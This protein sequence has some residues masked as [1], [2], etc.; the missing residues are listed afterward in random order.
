MQRSLATL[1]AD[2]DLDPALLSYG[3]LSLDLDGFAVAVRGQDVP[4]TLS[5]FLLLTAFARN[6]YRVL[7]RAALVDVLRGSAAF[8]GRD[9]ADLRLIDRHISRLRKKLH[10][11]GCDCIRTMRFAGYR[12]IPPTG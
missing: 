11:A 4:V 8:D 12:F 2:A 1:V 10:D 7:D 3:P 5:E 9:G 6:P